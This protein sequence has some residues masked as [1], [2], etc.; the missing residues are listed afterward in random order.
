MIQTSIIHNP[1]M[2]YGNQVPF[3]PSEKFP[4]L[5]DSNLSIEENLVFAAVRQSFCYSG[6][7][8][9]NFG[10]P[11]WNPFKDLVMPGDVVVIKPNLVVDSQN[12]D[13]QT[14]ITTHASLIRPIID[15][16]WKA[17]LGKGEIIIG[18]APLAEA[19]FERIVQRTQIK[20]MVQTLKERGVNINLKDF[21]SI[22]VIMKNGIWIDEQPTSNL[23]QESIE[24]NLANKSLLFHQNKKK[25][26][27]GG[28][29]KET[30]QVHHWGD[31]HEYK[32]AKKI[33]EANVVICVPKLKTHNKAGI[34]CCL[35][36]LVG[37]NV[38]KNY[39]P[40]F[41]KGPMNLG[42]DE[43]PMVP[44]YRVPLIKLITI[45][46][47]Y[48]L[49]KNW[50]RTGK[51]IAPLLK[52]I[53]NVFNRGNNREQTDGG[54]PAK[55][56]MQ[57]IAAVPVFQGS[58]SGNDTIWRMILDLNRIFLYVNSEGRI[59]ES[60]CRRVFYV[61]D[62]I[63][64]GEKN[65]PL[66]P[67]ELKIGVVATG[68]NALSVDLALLKYLNIDYNKIPLYKNAITNQNW[69]A[70]DGIDLP[71]INGVVQVGEM[72]LDIQMGFLI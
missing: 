55:W 63:T 3:D 7:D 1:A 62:A 34:T 8:K 45:L 33:L 19:D 4:E 29:G 24:I 35:K 57:S 21:R 5:V 22:K 53:Y 71:I 18:D 44:W 10:T 12:A 68:N 43:F 50:K 42:G 26:Q 6:L 13:Q 56:L 54:S 67:G 66:Y 17:M 32:V 31:I 36:N 72:N 30:T 20:P 70:P 51:Y 9:D 2:I 47:D 39:L 28:Y 46:R 38:D 11:G 15:Y 52:G 16:C 40:H 60:P 23:P 69:L 37:I 49:D 27:G 25:Y 58:W 59:N 14:S 41:T 65:G 61:V 48:L 64:I